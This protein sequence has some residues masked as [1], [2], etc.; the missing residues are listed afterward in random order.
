MYARIS[1]IGG[2]LVA[3]LFSASFSTA[4]AQSTEVRYASSSPPNTV[5]AMQT[6]RMAK[7]MSEKS[8]GALKVNAFINS[9][10]GSEQDTIQQVARG[11]ID[12]GGYSITAGSLLVPELSLLNMPFLFKNTAEQDCVFDNHVTKLASELFAKKGVQFLGWSHVGETSIVGKKPIIKPEDLK[13]LKARAQPTKLGPYLWT[14]FGANP[15]PLP[16]TEVNSAFQSG[17]VDVGDAPIT[18]YMFSGVN[19]VAPVMS[20]T[21][22]LDHGGVVLMNKAVY[23]KLPAPSRKALDD[24]D[25]AA[26]ATLLRKEV[27][28]FEAKLY[29][30]HKSQGGTIV[31]LSPEQREVW[32]KEMT[33]AW[34]KM[35]EA[36]GGESNAMWQAIQDGIK[37]CA[38]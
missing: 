17:L 34:P 10:L 4:Q 15:N 6:E 5:W 28:E 38:R 27:R 21:K 8:G 36:I 24:A 1:A 20:M 25:Q 3:C 29:G 32:R 35:V 7:L 11:R 33:A 30:M 16:V 31:E 14:T 37:A 12:M 2:T 9:Q 13:G 22:H 23:D 18:Y 26:P 19:K